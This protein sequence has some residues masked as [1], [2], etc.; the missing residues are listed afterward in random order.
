MSMS[1]CKRAYYAILRPEKV[2]I[3]TESGKMI[4]I[5]ATDRPWQIKEFGEKINA[6]SATV[7]LLGLNR[8][9]AARLFK[10]ME[11]PERRRGSE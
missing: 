9:E 5:E 2:K 3:R 4:V 1:R 10:R 8:A 6:Y 11:E 7:Y